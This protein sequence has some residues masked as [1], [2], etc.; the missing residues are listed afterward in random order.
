MSSEKNAFAT[1]QE[2]RD[3]V[4]S[5][6]PGEFIGDAEV[7]VQPTNK[8]T[9]NITEKRQWYLEHHGNV[10]KMASYH[11]IQHADGR[12]WFKDQPYC[13]SALRV[14]PSYHTELG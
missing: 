11:F 4:S 7:I 13:R 12:H 6:G 14:L 9:K 5:L 10:A 1:E 8:P 3:Y 2:M